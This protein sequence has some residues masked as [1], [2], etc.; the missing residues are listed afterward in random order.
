MVVE[1][2]VEDGGRADARE[3]WPKCRSPEGSPRGFCEPKR[4]PSLVDGLFWLQLQDSNL[5]PG[6]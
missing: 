4:P 3:D 5:R 2:G 1:S 6:G